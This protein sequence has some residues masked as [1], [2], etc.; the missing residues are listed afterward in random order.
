MSIIS[1]LFKRKDEKPKIQSGPSEDAKEMVEILGCSC[2]IIPP[3]D[4]PEA[5]MTM[6]LT[7]YKSGMEKG[8][9]PVFIAS[10]TALLETLD[11][12]NEDSGGAESYRRELLKTDT[13]NGEEYLKKMFDVT[14]SDLKAEGLGDEEVYGSEGEEKCGGGKPCHRFSGFCDYGSK[15]SRE[16]ILAR[17]PAKP[18]EVFAWV[19]FGGWNECPLPEDMMRTSKY[20]YSKYGA[21][22]AVITSDTLEFYLPK[23]VNDKDEAFKIACQQY[24]FCTDIVDQGTGSIRALA[25]IIKGSTVWFFWWD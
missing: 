21:V 18:W 8:Y 14:V 17:I 3:S 2:E 24:G 22:P 15:K 6:Y 4:D 10:N 20:W 19:P 23:A 16:M 25:G 13:S 9:T 7:E 5:L 1:N 11:I 12:N